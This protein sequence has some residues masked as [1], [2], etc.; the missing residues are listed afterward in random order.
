MPA[1][2]S[3]SPGCN[4]LSRG[5]F[6]QALSKLPSGMGRTMLNLGSM[7][8]RFVALVIASMIATNA[9]ATAVSAAPESPGTALS[10]HIRILASNPR[11][12]NS[13]I[14]AGRAALELGDV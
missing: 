11:D 3:S 8:A 14:G 9:P 1:C 10:R 6:Q 2:G 13:L 12:F 4:D 5:P 7:R